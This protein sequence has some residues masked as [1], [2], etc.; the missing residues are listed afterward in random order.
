MTRLDRAHP[1]A[2]FAPGEDFDAYPS[3]RGTS[4]KL[5]AR[6]DSVVYSMWQQS[7]PIT[8]EQSKFYDTHGYLTFDLGLEQAGR[9]ALEREMERLWRRAG[10]LDQDSI[11]LEPTSREI[12][13]I[14]RVHEIS[15]VFARLLSDRRLVEIARYLLADEVAIHQSRLNFKPGFHGKEFYWHSDFETWHIEDGMP[16]M[17]AL[18]MSISLTENTEFNGPL[19]LIPR[20]HWQ[21]VSC[22]GQT[23]DAHYKSS[24]RKQEYGVPDHQSLRMLVDRGG[25]VAPKGPAGTVTIFDCNTMH[26]SN[27]NITPFPRSNVFVVYNAMSNHLVEPFGGKPPRPDFL[28]AREPRAVVVNDSPF[29]S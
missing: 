18:S 15:P 1:T 12:R 21:F 17:R 4:P 16:R 20:S 6:K 28:A 27:G 8:E 22:V 29:P 13:S 2:N 11:I 25:L 14:F 5:I 19:M 9:T 26:G 24:L 3:R 23:P 7:A 10:A